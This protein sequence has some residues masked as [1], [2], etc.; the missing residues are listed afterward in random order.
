M[1]IYN[2]NANSTLRG[3]IPAFMVLSNIAIF[4]VIY[5]ALF[6]TYKKI[7]ENTYEKI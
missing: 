5:L 7:K 6:I 1:I 2:K 4:A 3:V